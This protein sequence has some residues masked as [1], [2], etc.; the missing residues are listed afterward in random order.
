MNS[1]GSRQEA[2]QVNLTAKATVV[3]PVLVTSATVVVLV[4]LPLPYILLV[5]IAPH[6]AVIDAQ[7]LQT[8]SPPPLR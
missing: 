8:E 4:Q 2:S 7:S 5:I 1:T 6:N 3:V